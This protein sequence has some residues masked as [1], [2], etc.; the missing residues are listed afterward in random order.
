[1]HGF[2]DNTGEHWL[3]L[4]KLYRLL[5][6]RRLDLVLHY[7]VDK[8]SGVTY[9]MTG[10]TVSHEDNAYMIDAIKTQST[11]ILTSNYNSTIRSGNFEINIGL[12]FQ[13]KLPFSTFDHLAPN[14]EG[15]CVRSFG[16]GWWYSPGKA[17]SSLNFNGAYPDR[18]YIETDSGTPIWG[19][20]SEIKIREEVVLDTQPA[21]VESPNS[22]L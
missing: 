16:A 9:Y 12:V 4:D 2:G 22:C 15:D 19:T 7:R 18:S 13:S 14:V 8:D 20:R 3:G 11:K 5:N 10:V 1:V 21:D 17:C 6:G